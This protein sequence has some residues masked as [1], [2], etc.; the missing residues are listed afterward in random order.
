[1]YFSAS[2][3]DSSWTTRKK[4]QL[5]LCHILFIIS[6]NHNAMCVKTFLAKHLINVLLCPSY[7]PDFIPSLINEKFASSG[8]L[9]RRVYWRMNMKI[10][11]LIFLCLTLCNKYSALT[12]TES[13]TTGDKT[14]D[15]EFK[16][17]HRN[18]RKNEAKP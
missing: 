5:E 2:S 10:F 18:G 3:L 11:M 7:S 12:F 14:W 4:K 9:L 13:L 1:M 16:K 15:Y 6:L 8:E 17:H